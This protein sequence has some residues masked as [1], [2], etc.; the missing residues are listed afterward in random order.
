MVLVFG[1]FHISINDGDRAVHNRCP[2]NHSAQANLFWDSP[3]SDDKENAPFD[4]ADT[5]MSDP[6]TVKDNTVTEAE[7]IVILTA[8]NTQAWREHG[9]SS[10][11]TRTESDA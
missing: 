2:M 9:H 11:L 1:S 7:N 4:F 3:A 10:S 8:N 6:F 5:S